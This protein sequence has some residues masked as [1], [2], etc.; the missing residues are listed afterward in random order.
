MDYMPDTST[1]ASA[2]KAADRSKRRSLTALQK[3]KRVRIVKRNQKR[4][5]KL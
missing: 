2:A 5:S 4:L 1:A 3:P